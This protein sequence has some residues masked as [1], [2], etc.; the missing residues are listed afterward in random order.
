MSFLFLRVLSHSHIFL[1]SSLLSHFLWSALQGSGRVGRSAGG[2]EASGDAQ[3]AGVVLSG[4]RGRLSRQSVGA[5]AEVERRGEAGSICDSVNLC[6][7]CD[8]FCVDF[9]NNMWLLWWFLLWFCESVT[10]IRVMILVNIWLW[11]VWW[12][13]WDE[14]V[15]LVVIC[16]WDWSEKR[17]QKEKRKGK[18]GRVEWDW[19]R[20]KIV[21]GLVTTQYKCE[22]FVPGISPGTNAPHHLYRK[23]CTI[24]ITG[25]NEG[26]W[27]IQIS[28]FSSSV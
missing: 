1:H 21:A 22:A 28:V 4:Q 10:V 19:R 18:G 2:A 5:S 25:T 7:F 8:E 11:I 16:W 23:V 14:S 9:V 17:K 26:Y 13:L 27:P 15:N 3:A 20:K 24:S 12:F 6:W